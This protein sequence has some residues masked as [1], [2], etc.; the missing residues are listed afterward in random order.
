L[1]AAAGA[2]VS[3]TNYNGE[4]EHWLLKLVDPAAP[5]LA[6]IFRHFEVDT[7]KLQ[8]DLTRTIDG[9]KTGNARTPALAVAIDKAIRE[10][11]LLASLQFQIPKIRSSV[12]LLALLCDDTLGRQARDA[13]RELAKIAPETLSPN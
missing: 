12:L 8:R 13:S 3:R 6:K 5:D 11:W 4:I 10:A 9:F 2:C 1:Q 7:S